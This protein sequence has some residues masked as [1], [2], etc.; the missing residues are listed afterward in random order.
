MRVDRMRTWPKGPAALALVCALVFSPGALALD[1]AT[2]P[3]FLDETDSRLPARS[4]ATYDVAVGDVDGDA[5]LDILVANGGQSRLWIND[6]GFFTDETATRLPALSD[7]T[8]SVVA[9][10]VD[11]DD[12]EDLFL[13]NASG[14]NRLLIND[15]SGHFADETPGRLPALVQVSISAAL[16]DLD[17]DSDLDL[18]VA[19]RGSQNR[20]LVNN[21]A[22]VF[23]DESWL[24][25][26]PDSDRTY[27]VELLDVEGN[28]SLDIFLLNQ[29]VSSRLLVNDGLGFFADLTTSRLPPLVVEGLDA[30][31]ADV[32]GDGAF[33]LVLAAGSSGMKILLND[34]SGA[35]SDQTAARA[36]PLDA[37]PIQVRS[38]D[39][40][41]DGDLDLVLAAAGQDRLLFNE[42]TGHFL[43]ATPDKLPEDTRRSFGLALFDADA[44]LDLDVLLARPRG[45]TRLLV[46]D[47]PY[48]RL[49]LSVSP[50]I[51]EVGDPVTVDIT[52]FDEDGLF[53]ATLTL[54]SPAG[55]TDVDVLAD[56]A[57][58]TAAHV[59]T[60]TVVGPH[61]AT[62]TA[63]DV[64]G[65]R[66]SRSVAFDV[67]PA[68]VEA[69]SIT[70]ELQAPDPLL[71]G[72]VVT[73]R[74]NVTDDRVVISKTL[75]VN[76]SPVPLNTQG[77][78]AY[79]PS[80]PGTYAVAATATDA[81]GNVGTASTSFTVGADVLPPVVGVT[82][83]PP[84]VDLAQVVTATVV[85]SDNVA[86]VARSLV[87]NGP[88]TTGD[89][90][91]PLDAAGRATYKPFQPG[92]YTFTARASDASGNE[93]V[94][95]T[96]FDA[97]G[98]PD[99][100]P[101]ALALSI[102]PHTVPI[103][104]S[105]TIGVIASDDVGVS[106]TR[107]EINGTPMAIDPSGM[108]VFTPPALG[109]YVATGFARDAT[110]N[111]STATDTFRA[112]DPD[113]DDTAPVVSFL[114]PGDA[115]VIETLTDIVGTA[116]DDTLVRYELSASYVN[117][118]TFTPFAEGDVSVVDGVLGTFDPTLRENGLYRV[119]LL[120]E[121][122]NGLI[123]V[124][125]R[126]FEVAGEQKV[127][128][129]R[130][131]FTDVTFPF[132]GLPI[133]VIRTYDSR[134]K[135][136]RDFGV[137]WFLETRQSSFQHN[138][139]P[140]VGWQFQSGSLGLPCLGGAVELAEHVSTVKLSDT[141]SYR[142]A[143]RVVSPS[144][145]LGGCFAT[146]QYVQVDGYTPGATLSILGNTEVFW[147]SG[148]TELVEFD[149]F[150][151]Y[152]VTRV[153]LTTRD[154]RSFD[155]D[156][157]AGL[158]RAQDR[159][160]NVITF[161][162]GGISSSTGRS[163]SFTRDGSGRIRTITDPKGN[164]YLYEYDANGDL[165]RMVEPTLAETT[166]TYDSR[167]NLL[168]ILDPRGNRA[169]R[170]EYDDD[171]RLVATIDALGNRIEFEND[172]GNSQV[173]RDRLG[174]VRVLEYDER[175]NVTS[176]THPDGTI[177]T[178]THDAKGNELTVT[179]PLGNTTTFTYDAAN[180]R[181][182]RTD[183]LG[184]S[185]TWTYNS[186]NQVLVHVDAEGGT[187]T[188][189]YDAN[190]NLLTET[191]PNGNVVTRA[192]DAVGNV[193]SL[194]DG[195][196]ATT[197]TAYDSASN[198]ISVTDPLGNVQ[199][200]TY[201]ANGNVLTETRTRLV[202]GNPEALVTTHVYDAL[203]RLLRTTY[204][205]GGVMQQGYDENGNLTSVID[206]LGRETGHEYDELN[207]RVRTIHPDTTTEE[208]AYD[209]EG[210][211]VSKTDRRGETTSYGYNLRGA[212][213]SVTAPDGSVKTREYDDALRLVAT[214][215]GNGNRTA[216]V[217]D[218]AGRIVRITDPLGNATRNT[219]D[220]N[221]NR[222]TEQDAKARTTT[223][224]YDARRALTR[225]VF[226]DG[227]EERI[228][229]TP[230]YPPAPARVRDRAGRETVYEYD[231]KM[232]LT[233]VADPM[234]NT[235]AF[236]YDEV[237]NR[238]SQ[239]D[240]NGRITRFAHDSRGRE[241]RRTLPG[242]LAQLRA[243]DLAGNLIRRTDF[244]G[245]VTT[246]AYDEMNR[247]VERLHPDGTSAEW[248]YTPT[249]MV[250]SVTDVRGSATYG[251]DVRDRLTSIVQPGNLGLTYAYDPGSRLTSLAAT[252]GG[253]S[254]SQTST[255][256]AADRLLT[257]TDPLGRPY[258]FVHDAT[259][260][261]TTL[262]HPN[263]VT[264]SHTY[265][266]LDQMVSLVT[267]NSS[268]AVLQSYGYTIGADGNR[269]R[270]VEADGTTR[271][272]L[273]DAG[274]R[275][276]RETVAGPSGPVSDSLYGYDPASNLVQVD[277]VSSTG[278]STRILA[279]DERDRLLLDGATAFTWDEDGRLLTR[280]G[281]AGLI[282]VWDSES[283][284][285]EAIHAN[286][287]VEQ[288]RYD[289]AGNRVETSVTPAGGPT[290]TTRFL[291][292]T[293]GKLSHVVAEVTE[294]G[295]IQA[296]Y[297][298]AG[299][300][301]L[302][303]VRPTGTRFYHADA[304]GSVRRLTDET[305]A[306]TDTYTFD[307]FGNLTSRTGSDPNPYLF[308]GEP[309]G[310]NLDLYY[311][312]ARWLDPST[313]RFLSMD[314]FAGD[315]E[316]PATL[317]RYAYAF[318]N[319]VNFTDPS[320]EMGLVSVSV[321]INFSANVRSANATYALS[322]LHRVKFLLGQTGRFTFRQLQQIR[323]ANPNLYKGLENHHLIEKR[324]WSRI[325]DLQKIFRTTDDIP[326]AF[327]SKA[328]H[329]LI[330]NA[331]QQILGR[332]GTGTHIPYAN[333]TLNEVRAAVDIVYAN[334]PALRNA[335]LL[336]LI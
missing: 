67:L 239:T 235:W 178:R 116:E 137:G 19:N 280:S 253:F 206:P 311:N 15:G 140:G 167:H 172:V 285:V 93:G 213:E 191:D 330:T 89:L 54:T 17:S 81:A 144:P 292:D 298:R 245:A 170:S 103:G 277:S 236:T 127:G 94:G 87:V 60:P 106:E 183:A 152:D 257:V 126:V 42:G 102:A 105:V 184:N 204:P 36:P 57:D 306:V 97:Q 163:V 308:A 156:R 110:G 117:E 95:T 261:R 71:V 1:D 112:V 104:D 266:Q 80:A 237:G 180:N 55:D 34:G 128:N 271:D 108:V 130:L 247:L 260:K 314:P 203:G 200:F 51:I 179:D 288:H 267:R 300:E 141:E 296:H 148:S 173:V 18:V 47:I 205:D 258:A 243:Y 64:L 169:V 244:G 84:V 307:A 234:G 329:Q 177:T 168:E 199:S 3:P 221:G 28:G 208:T 219:Y 241:I 90:P 6:S 46:N 210:Q 313:G 196:G 246:Y 333:L 114:E 111:E 297:V 76:G 101:P 274:N 43:E 192:Y 153:R 7:T 252:V 33:D 13:A 226:P 229:Y 222:I 334:W 115:A 264:T 109:E 121:D 250:A 238:T 318:D 228:T 201:D 136:K 278:A 284:L 9:G 58:G 185:E 230:T 113:A 5:D 211:I 194:T 315:V 124:T 62:L 270:V 65:N 287:T 120:A 305:G 312:R 70:L 142:F 195:R 134:I 242:G 233:S 129:F 276:T 12:D 25:L 2:L 85:A 145:T 92:T 35:F 316:Q 63:F 227:T 8:L 281:P 212:L 323:A 332:A 328:D 279:Y 118:S 61:L 50:S 309:A 189:T 155:L 77:A 251:Y 96:T 31:P 214:R 99:S 166:F 335:L 220:A 249:G 265:N 165:V 224:E 16:G 68:D 133:D 122:V 37:F 154:R 40:D 135:S 174:R 44:D 56:L 336:A 216:M 263:G 147:V 131:S 215:D 202:N 218:D 301:L 146:A 289:A 325:P 331:W 21:G 41:F 10:D 162:P 78:G 11:G 326:S 100:T 20:I 255:Y 52:A 303:V 324:F 327:L 107:L 181:T 290:S 295:S 207:R 176:E 304:L 256:D 123:S 275:L 175:G 158:T 190:G 293:R 74:V 164:V 286:G 83:A 22:G 197:L 59:F 38:G 30:E 159:N 193:I 125:E 26:L 188:F 29:G 182:S 283:R 269:S 273:Y 322:V 132:A 151:V 291:V 310:A 272:Y 302:S 45:Q 254:Q 98:T 27:D 240:P 317:H 198:L 4:D 73:I 79:V 268:S 160:G 171:G 139:T 150:D 217:L 69:P 209:A 186:F 23:T 161:G 299:D 138:R 72:H 259:G 232:Q 294:G 143:L 149:T 119:R 39:V 282:N 319:P 223:F 48:P 86:V 262:S 82:A 32:D 14:T 157:S 24:L 91:L 225:T 248:T 75:M 88:G 49:L 53:S 231:L 321:S 66:S 187:E 320:G